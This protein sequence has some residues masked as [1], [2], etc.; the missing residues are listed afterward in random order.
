M[1][2]KPARK[3]IARRRIRQFDRRKHSQRKKADLYLR[4]QQL[5]LRRR[6][7]DLKRSLRRTNAM[8]FWCD[9]YAGGAPELEQDVKREEP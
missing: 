5:G 2:L 8:L 6:W 1:A 9:K 7:R 3:F 4:K